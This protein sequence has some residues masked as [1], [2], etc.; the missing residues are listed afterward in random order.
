MKL[1][2]KEKIPEA[3]SAIVDG[4]VQLDAGATKDA[5]AA[6]VLSSDRSK[7]YELYWRGDL[8]YSNDNASYWQAY[9]G[10]PV[11]AILMHFGR[12]PYDASAAAHFRAINWHELNEHFKRDY[13][14]AL[15]EL[16]STLDPPERA[17]TTE[18][19]DNCYTHLGRLSLTLTRKKSL[20]TG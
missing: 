5:G 6:S 8:F 3:Y 12:L 18:A 17:A 14:R 13:E 2:P 7:R 11:L 9:P 10:Y 19:I 20:F 4:R 15:D 1:P 16:L